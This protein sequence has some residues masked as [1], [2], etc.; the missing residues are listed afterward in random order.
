MDS[1]G[2][3]WLQTTFKLS[4]VQ[5]LAIESQIGKT[6][7]S[8]RDADDR[9][10]ETFQETY[11]P[12]DS[13]EGHLAFALTY[14][15]IHL[16]LLS[17]L[18]ALPEAR[19]A[20]EAWARREPTGSYSRRACFLAE[21]LHPESPLNVPSVTQGNYADALNPNDFFVGDSI[22]NP[23]WRVNDNL[24]GSVAYC[25]IIRRTDALRQAESYDIQER[26]TALEN[27]FGVDLILKSAVW[28]TIKESRAS[29]QIEREHDKE[30]RVRRFAAVME[31]EC[32]RHEDSLSQESLAALQKGILGDVAL[33][34]GLRQ[35]PVY[36]GHDAYHQPIVDYIAPHWDQTQ[37]LLAGLREFMVRTK[38]R[39]PI[40]RAAVAA[41]GFVYI[42][43][44]AD[45]NG[46]ISRFLINDV[47]RRDK[48]VPKPIVLPISATIA[49]SATARAAYD[50]ILEQ[51]SKPLMSTFADD[52]RFGKHETGNDGVNYNF[53]FDRYSDA[54]PAWRY[55][56]LT[57]HVEYMARVIDTTLTQEMRNEAHFLRA[58]SAARESIKNILEAPDNDLDAIIR[59]IR[60]NEYALSNKLLKTYPLL[61]GHLGEHV[62]S[63]IMASFGETRDDPL[64][65][66]VER[67]TRI[68]RK[69][70]D[71][72]P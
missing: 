41:F 60:Q 12:D 3:R 67:T 13:L 15:G 62:A 28:L 8:Y 18:F 26:I 21:W 36:V 66:P 7:R 65:K 16:E 51:F 45:G 19:N 72:S 9:R 53:I 58:N 10:L 71:P 35:S 56:D 1:V 5:P 64:R 48:A 31:S 11:R 52:Y 39:A 25:P 57:S 40:V 27:D 14:E 37:G 23:R 38:G 33:R 22:R 34:Y 54:L 50:S 20:L 44:M 43:P 2:Y 42:H 70:K 32:G 49:G 68:I 17:R 69:A 46:R 24:P 63:I 61:E 6:R 30:D 4:V 59:S 55:Q 47:L 29:F